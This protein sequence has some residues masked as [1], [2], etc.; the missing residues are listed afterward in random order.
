ME[1]VEARELLE[2]A[3][4]EPGG[5]ERLTAGDTPESAALAGHIAGCL[6]CATEMERLRRAS[7]VI[8][9]ALRAAPPADLRDRTLAFVAAVGRPR[10]AGAVAA[11]PGGSAPPV[12]MG[13]ARAARRGVPGA[14][15]W[16]TAMAA[17]VIVA[18]VGTTL[19]VTRS[20]ETVTQ[21]QAAQIA[22][23]GKV[24]TWSLRIDGESDA[25]YVGLAATNGNAD[26]AGTLAF[27]P[28][29]K[30][31]VVLAEGLVPPPSGMQYRCWVEI[32]GT[33]KR[34]GQMFFGG[35]VAYWVGSVEGLGGVGMGTRF[36]VSLVPAD[37]DSLTADPVLLGDL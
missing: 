17:A 18:I 19:F 30:E 33:R 26:L 11:A 2:L 34:I 35:G 14:A 10:G 20:N 21:A 15:L 23:L 8:R 36:G 7:V 37:G 12:D 5:F 13:R 32:D 25:K 22:S 9:E 1:H 16:A 27:S 4:V 3:A 31:L 24:A 28:Q 29:S 6:E